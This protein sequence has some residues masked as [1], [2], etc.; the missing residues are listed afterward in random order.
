MRI[1]EQHAAI[2]KGQRLTNV[3]ANNGYRSSSD[4]NDSTAG[5]ARRSG[6]DQTCEPPHSTRRGNVEAAPIH[7]LFVASRVHPVSMA[8]DTD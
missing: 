6:I 2:E 5:P 8:G 7:P 3:D 4:Q 1:Q